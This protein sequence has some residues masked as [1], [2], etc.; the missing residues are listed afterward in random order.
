MSVYDVYGHDIGGGGSVNSLFLDKAYLFKL[1]NLND[2][3]MCTDGTYIYSCDGTTVRKSNILTKANTSVSQTS[4]FFGHAN[5]MTYNPNTGYLYIVTS[6][7][8]KSVIV[9]DAS[10]LSYVETIILYKADGTAAAPTQIAYD[11]KNDQYIAAAGSDYRFYDSSFTCVKSFDAN[12]GGTNQDLETDG[13]YIYKCRSSV[14]SRG[15]IQ[16]IDFG[17]NTIKQIDVTGDEIES[18]AYDW[19]GNWY[20][21]TKNSQGLYYINFLIDYPMSAVAQ[22]SR[23]ASAY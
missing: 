1:K 3:G 20:V 9:V 2:Q 22:L 19:N 14:K 18:V 15:I 7:S 16:V 6:D 21:N 12:H 4:G 8:T 23:I 13:Q 5:G 17:G 10:D 11:R